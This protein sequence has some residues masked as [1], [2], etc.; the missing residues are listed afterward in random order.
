MYGNN[1]NPAP[2]TAGAP[3]RR[4]G[5]GQLGMPCNRGL[6]CTTS[7]DLG[8]PRCM[9]MAPAPGPRP[10]PRPTPRPRPGLGQQCLTGQQ[11]PGSGLR[12]NCQAGLVCKPTG[13][14]MGGVPIC[15]EPKR[16]S[17]L[18]SYECNPKRGEPGF[19]GLDC[20]ARD[21]GNGRYKTM[22]ECNKNCASAKL[23]RYMCNPDRNQMLGSKA[24]IMT[25]SNDHSYST[26]EECEKR[27]G[28]ATLHTGYSCPRGTKVGGG[29]C[30][31]VAGIPGVGGVFRDPAHCAVGSNCHAKPTSL[32]RDPYWSVGSVESNP[33]SF[34][35]SNV[36]DARGRIQNFMGE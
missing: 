7:G 2:G 17:G 1:N 31:K 24:C 25:S 15:Q 19:N 33:L 10:T 27:C 20:I 23:S 13:G 22:E 35:M 5:S 18:R 34:M 11:F 16:P 8:V 12:G 26:E 28:S 30:K 4:V 32:M 29:A 6:K 21:D 36:G 3:C 14:D 9:P